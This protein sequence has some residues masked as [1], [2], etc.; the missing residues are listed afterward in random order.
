MKIILTE[1]GEQLVYNGFFSGKTINITKVKFGD[2]GGS[3]YTPNKTM[4]AL[5]NHIV[6]GEGNSIIKTIN[7]EQ[8]LINSYIPISIGNVTIREL[9]LYDDEDRLIAIGGEFERYKPSTDIILDKMD[10]YITIP[11]DVNIAMSISFTNNSL[12]VGSD[13]LL[14]LENDLEEQYIELGRI[15]EILADAITP[16]VVKPTINKPISGV[17]DF[18]G[19]FTSSDYMTYGGFT[20]LLT[21]VV[22]QVSSNS[23]FTAI[24]EEKITTKLEVF[25]PNPLTPLTTYYVRLRHISGIHKSYWSDTTIFTTPALDLGTDG[26][27]VLLA[28]DN[29]TGGFYGELNSTQLIDTRD[30][31]GSYRTNTLYTANQQVSHSGKLWN[32]IVNVTS[33]VP[34]TDITKWVED[35]RENLPTGKWLLDVCGVGYGLRDDNHDGMS[36]GGVNVGPLQNNDSGWLKFIKDN[37][38]MYIAKKPFVN[39]I[40]WNDLAKRTLVYGD[41]TVR[42]G[43]RLYWIRLI[44]EEEYTGCLTRLLD[45][46]LWW[47]RSDE[48]ALTEKTW[49]H[50]RQ[51]GL[52]RKTMSDK[53]V[54]TTI[55]P[56]NRIGAYR[57]VLELIPIGAEPYNNLPVCP[58]ATSENFQY[59]QY[60]D[61]GYFGVT[62]ASSLVTGSVLASALGITEGTIQND[63]DGY[64]KFYWHGKIIYMAQKTFRSDLSWDHIAA[65]NAVF[66]VDLGGTGKATVG[67]NG[68]TFNVAIPTGGGKA[69]QDD[70]AYWANYGGLTS[71]TG[72]A[73]NVLLEIGKFSMWN[74]LMYRVHTTFVD[75]VLANQDED[76]N[77]K[78]LTG[79]VQIGDNWA[80]FANT[81]LSI[82]YVD[83]GNGTA[84]WCQETSSFATAHRTH[85]G[86][87]RLAYSFRFSSS[88]VAR[89][90]AWR[91][92]L[93]LN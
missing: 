84:T 38:T 89:D 25:I 28:G 6:D 82:Y 51:E 9:G 83:S 92:L 81:D 31:R 34:G 62:P 17:L 4:T 10:F 1:L 73:A 8:F 49:V 39:N 20:G 12:F 26:L 30:Y 46:D 87:Y 78:E 53:N 64:L 65:R 16:M 45:G 24:V 77:Y 72:F 32:A 5:V 7:P 52:V 63:A 67:A 48:L 61:T 76:A 35:T 86:L 93:I 21:S 80:T 60:T 19:P 70:V 55:S 47:Y 79:G 41:R 74:E 22:W 71:T 33:V 40:A 14:D 42:I 43:S 13:T 54:I 50:D 23:E 2:G 58:L 3:T 85:R 91:P 66:G 44:K 90:M 11:V 18:K 27:N 88:S 75:N 57:P 59:D 69:P 36:T 68:Y 56:K 15:N 29:I 37:K